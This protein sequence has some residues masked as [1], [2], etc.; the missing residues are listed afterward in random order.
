MRK[1]LNELFDI[2][3]GTVIDMSID[4]VIMEDEIYRVRMKEAKE[5]QESFED[6]GLTAEQKDRVEDYISSIMA[7]N[8]RACN[9]TYLIGA[10]NTIQFLGEVNAFKDDSGR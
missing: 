9:L 10:R 5:I 6:L 7:A 1:Y 8:E 2:G 3:M 4:K